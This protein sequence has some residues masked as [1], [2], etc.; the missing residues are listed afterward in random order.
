MDH[1]IKKYNDLIEHWER[2]IGTWD[3]SAKSIVL[4]GAGSKGI[5]FLNLIKNSAHL[6]YIVDIN[7]RK[8]S[9]FIPGTG[10]QIIAPAQLQNINPDIVVV[11]NPNYAEEIKAQLSNI[12]IDADVV[13][14]FDT[15]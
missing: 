14:V 2:K 13:S 6:S 3:Q 12:N 9:Y 4:W 7:P 1:F 15:D 10:H 11:M 8:T 5:S